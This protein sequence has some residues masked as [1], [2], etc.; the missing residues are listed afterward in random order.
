MKLLITGGAGFIGS[1]FV[2]YMLQQH[3]DYQIVNV[4]ALTYAGNL[5]NLKSI[6]NHP[7][8]TFVKAD[9]TDVTAMDELISQGVDV[10]VNFAAESHVDRSILEPEVFVKTNVLGTQVLLD[11]AKKYSITKFVQVSTD[12]VYGSLGATGLFTEETPLAPNS[13]YSAS[14]AGGDL[15]VRAYHETFGLPVNITRCS[16]NYGP[17]QFPEKL[18]PLM[19]SRA[20]ADQALPV[21][22]DGMNIRDWLYVEDHCSA[23]DLVIHKG[24]NGEVYNIGGN[25]ERTNVHIVN[26]VL[27]ELGKPDSLITYVQDRPGHDRR[28]GIDPTKIMNELGWKPKHTFETGIKETIQWYLNNREWWTRIQ[29]GEYQKYAEQQYGDRLGDS[30]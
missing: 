3:P 16:N 14:K 28:Y 8:Y 5:E 27:Q 18:I 23:I 17:Y 10:V 9:I 4:D 29:S 20:L 11:A 24:V 13:P 30:L 21:Y 1:N 6:E 15:L 22:G 19:I 26:T 2:L 25:N 7:N 12:E